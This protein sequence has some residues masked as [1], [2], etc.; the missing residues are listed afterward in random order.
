MALTPT[1]VALAS[2]MRDVVEGF[3]FAMAD[4]R[5]GEPNE[6]T[7]LRLAC[8]PTAGTLAPRLRAAAAHASP[9]PVVDV[10]WEVDVLSGLYG[11]DWSFVLGHAL[12]RDHDDVQIVHLREDPLRL[13]VSSDV[14][15]STVRLQDL[16]AA[17]LVLPPANLAPSWHERLLEILTTVTGREPAVRGVPVTNALWLEDLRGHV[18]GAEQGRVAYTVVPASGVPRH[19][20]SIPLTPLAVPLVLM[21]RKSLV[22]ADALAA[23]RIAVDELGGRR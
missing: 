13:I 10:Q 8:T 1:G 17:E 20:H 2:R 18:D 7:P 9:L 16:G 14:A 6:A 3:D 11:G 5:P 12:P 15:G 22:R 21:S 19:I 23:L 4:A